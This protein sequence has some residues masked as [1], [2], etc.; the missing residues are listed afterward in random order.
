MTRVQVKLARS[1]VNIGV[2]DYLTFWGRAGMVARLL[3]R[4]TGLGV[5]MR[6]FAHVL[7]DEAM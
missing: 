2:E 4:L 3:H 6:V 1:R 5:L 7:E